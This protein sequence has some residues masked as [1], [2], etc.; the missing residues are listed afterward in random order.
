MV[1][2]AFA[3]IAMLAYQAISGLTL[4]GLRSA[5]LQFA[6]E[7]FTR[8]RLAEGIWG[9]VAL[10]L[11]FLVPVAARPNRRADLMMWGVLTLGLAAT[12]ALTFSSRPARPLWTLAESALLAYAAVIAAVRLVKVLAGRAVRMAE[13]WS[14]LALQWLLLW[15]A[16]YVV[17]AW[18]APQGIDPRPREV[19]F[20]AV[21]LGLGVHSIVATALRCLPATER[22]MT[23]RGT[24]VAL[25][26]YNLGLILALLDYRI[27]AL[28]FALPALLLL[29]VANLPAGVGVIGK[30]F[31]HVVLVLLAGAWVMLPWE[32]SAF[33]AWRH[34][35]GA[36]VL[37]VTVLLTVQL[38]LWDAPRGRV[39]MLLGAAGYVAGVG[40][41]IVLEIASSGAPQ[42]FNAMFV[43]A[44]LEAGSVAVFVV[45]AWR[46]A[47]RSDE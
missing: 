12:V 45:G 19:L 32:N 14:F 44:L 35:A 3:L 27:V 26:L 20:T 16:A 46:G 34:A 37:G 41:R 9:W 23:Q 21:V 25:V 5:D 13:I 2:L 42:L 31:T 24:L 29:I 18:R 33:S 36:G 17:L 40:L 47:I 28:A 15:V 4:L 7:P 22:V 38:A 10:A 6:M 30:F 39:I 1:L 8:L 11:F 43:S